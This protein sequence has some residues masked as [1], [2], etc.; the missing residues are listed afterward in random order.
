MTFQRFEHLSGKKKR[1]V[2]E[3]FKRGIV[4]GVKFENNK[5]IVSDLAM[6]PYTEGRPKRES[7]P[8]VRKAILKAAIHHKSTNAA[9]FNLSPQI[10]DAYVS[11]LE[12]RGLIR[13][14]EDESFP[15]EKFVITTSA[16][17]D[18]MRSRGVLGKDGIIAGLTGKAIEAAVAGLIKATM[19]KAA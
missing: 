10:Y 11:D 1:T 15:G 19:G 6:P 7:A 5:W 13:V 8:S 4:P 16:T 9:V 3:W 2:L 12:D 18:Y 14:L 17:D